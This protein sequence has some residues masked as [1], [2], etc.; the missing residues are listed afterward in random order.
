MLAMPPESGPLFSVVMP[1]YNKAAHIARSLGSVLAQ[2]FHDFE[3]VVVDDGS[4][5]A[6]PSFV[7]ACG[8]SRVRLVRQQNAGVSAARNRGIAEARGAWVAFLDADDEYD[9]VFLEKVA[10]AIRRFPEAGAVYGVVRWRREGRI[11]NPMPGSSGGARELKDYL[12]EI[13]W[14]SGHEMCSSA[15]AVRRDVFDV[16][17]GFPVGVRVGEDS[18]MWLRVGWATSVGFIPEFVATYLMDAGDS[19]WER[20]RGGVPYWFGTYERWLKE[21]RIP[22]A[23]RRSAEAYRQKYLLERALLR[24]LAN[25]HREARRILLREVSFRAAPKRLW[26][27]TWVRALLPLSRIIRIIRGTSA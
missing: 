11:L 15:V 13:V 2:T 23:L 17:G 25:D 14:G 16:T 20:H 22:A 18:D 24:A 19:G 8:D 7:A 3:V 5:D 12:A 10:D 27:K 4:A 6:G 21:G 1:L 26:L 9:G